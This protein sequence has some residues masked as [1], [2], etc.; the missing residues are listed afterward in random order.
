MNF[1]PF[2]VWKF[3]GSQHRETFCLHTAVQTW[4]KLQQGRAFP[5][6]WYIVL[7]RV[8][9]RLTF[10]IRYA[11]WN[12]ILTLVAIFATSIF[13]MKHLGAY[14]KRYE[15]ETGMTS[16]RWNVFKMNRQIPAEDVKDLVPCLRCF[17]D[18]VLLESK[19]FNFFTSI[20]NS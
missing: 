5:V 13:G 15:R 14:N 9:L 7:V 16:V 10:F 11:V 20:C 18:L 2:I 19:M 3:Y 6:L 8:P 12:P 1:S 4:K 17:S